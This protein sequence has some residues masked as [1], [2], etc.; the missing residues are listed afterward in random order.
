MSQ[1][2]FQSVRLN[3]CLF[4][5]PFLLSGTCGWHHE[6]DFSSIWLSLFFKSYLSG[7]RKTAYILAFSN[8][9]L[10]MVLRQ[11]CMWSALTYN[12][13]HIPVWPAL[14]FIL[15]SLSIFV[16]TLLFYFLCPFNPHFFVSWVIAEVI[17]LPESTEG[18]HI[19][20][21]LLST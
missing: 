10:H 3:F 8:L 18:G 19:T 2:H 17:L 20:Q 5:L 12:Q 4:S 1:I 16:K 21:E 14:P 9:L 11:H 15:F 7:G 6:M 13:K